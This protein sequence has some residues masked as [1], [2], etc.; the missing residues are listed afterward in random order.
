MNKNQENMIVYSLLLLFSL[1]IDHKVKPSE[2]YLLEYLNSF[3]S[4]LLVVPV[5][6]FSLS[7][8]SYNIGQQVQ[9]AIGIDQSQ[10]AP[11]FAS[12][13]EGLTSPYR[14]CVVM[15]LETSRRAFTRG[16][17]LVFANLSC[18][19]VSSIFSY[20]IHTETF[21]IASDSKLQ[22]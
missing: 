14:R 5:R 10:I 6:V 22:S 21:F 7:S 8:V 18:V 4:T 1:E 15:L 17:K 16:C 11:R 2:P 3:F 12:T 20:L 19:Y 9:F 13:P